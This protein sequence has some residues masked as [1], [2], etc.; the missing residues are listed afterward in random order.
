[1]RRDRHAPRSR[2]RSTPPTSRPRSAGS[3]AVAAA[4]V[5]RQGRPRAVLRR[6]PGRG[7]EDPRQRRSRHLPR[8]EAARH[9]GH[10]RAAPPAR[11][12]RLAPTYL[13]VHA[14]GGPAM[15]AAAAEALP[16]TRIAAVT[17]L[18]LAVGR[19]PRAARHRRAAG[20]GGARGWRAS[21][22]TPARG[23]SC[24]RRRRWRWCA[25]RSG[26]TITLITP[27]VRPA[28]GD[29]TTRPGSRRR[30][31]RLPTAPTCSS[32]AARS[33]VPLILVGRL[34][35]L[36]PRCCAEPMTR[37]ELRVTRR[38]DLARFAAAGQRSS[39]GP[40]TMRTGRST[41]AR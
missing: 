36:P 6:R 13:T 21:P 5:D 9:P 32:S 12:P 40:S 10:G 35:R 27:G 2:S 7:R 22:S 34:R 17:V 26:P 15:I 8:P 20:R 19:R 33:P 4:R 11:S 18:D 30:S 16:D 28:G 14:A 29:A 24:A 25:R 1:M 31:R 3:T 39:V 37:T 41:T 38:P 23:R